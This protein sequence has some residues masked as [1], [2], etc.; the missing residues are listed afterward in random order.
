MRIVVCVKQ[1]RH[2]YARTGMDPRTHF[3]SE[4][5][6]VSIVN[7]LDELAVEA[8][9]RLRESAPGG[10]V[11]LLTLGELIAEPGLRHCLA[12]GADRII[13]I[14][15]PTV[16]TIDA[17]FTGVALAA[18][19]GRLRPDLVLCGKEALDDRCGEVG[20]LIAERLDLPCV[21]GVIQLDLKSDRSKAIVHRAMDRGDREVVECE[22]PAVFTVAR[23]L[24]EPRY[25][26]L[27]G[28]LGAEEAEIELWDLREL[29]LDPDATRPMTDVI[30]V[31]PPKPRARKAKAPASSLS[32]QARIQTL[33]RGKDAGQTREGSQLVELSPGEAAKRV[34]D[35]LVENGPL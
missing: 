23:G 26:A 14:H 3:L 10:E 11:I 20:F 2:V 28:L 6:T 30:R 22:L 32:A 33:M 1:I 8:A 17:W 27:E 19:I 35:F 34:L 7:P 13:R 4:A 16:E 29:D 18:A 24:N 12:M 31:S 9:I 21:S 15:D 5:D 25:P